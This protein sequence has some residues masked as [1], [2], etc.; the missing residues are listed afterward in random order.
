MNNSLDNL[1]VLR[2]DNV[3]FV[4][5]VDGYFNVWCVGCVD[6]Y[7]KGG[8]GRTK[9]SRSCVDLVLPPRA[10]SISGK[11]DAVETALFTMFVV[12]RLE[13]D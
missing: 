7:F 8:D 5:S 13:R 3:L 2:Y 6:G 12:T 11:D 4:V 10:I 1:A 9:L